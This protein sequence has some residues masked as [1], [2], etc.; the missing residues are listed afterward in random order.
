MIDDSDIEEIQDQIEKLVNQVHVLEVRSGMHRNIV[1]CTGCGKELESKYTHD[2][3]QCKCENGTFCD[4]GTEY[5]RIGGKDLSKIQVW[6]DGIF[7]EM[8]TNA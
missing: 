5:Q 6:K 1:F 2:F 4:G 7:E 3:Q 8:K